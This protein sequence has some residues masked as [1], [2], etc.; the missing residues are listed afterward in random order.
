MADK[1]ERR[2]AFIR[3]RPIC[4]R[5]LQDRTTASNVLQSLDALK[6]A[7]GDV[8]N[9]GLRGCQDYVLFP[10]L[11]IVDSIAV[12]R[13]PAGLGPAMKYSSE[14]NREGLHTSKRASNL[15]CV[16][17]AARLL[18]IG[19]LK[20]NASLCPESSRAPGVPAA[21][22]DRVAE[23]ALICCCTVLSRCPIQQPDLLRKLLQ[24]IA[25]AAA[26]PRDCA[27]EEVCHL[28]LAFSDPVSLTALLNPSCSSSYHK[29]ANHCSWEHVA[30]C[31]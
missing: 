1:D 12:S 20:L 18:S 5:L 3:L 4:S 9:G 25:P 17:P 7:L 21:Q 26:L 23:C 27:S 11:L 28:P 13:S 6:G 14:S 30:A 10:L 22:T 16:L 31:T 19:M 24:R 8:S 2:A 29:D 15:P